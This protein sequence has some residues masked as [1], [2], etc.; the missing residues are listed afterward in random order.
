MRWDTKEVGSQLPQLTAFTI[1]SLDVFDQDSLEE[2]KLR[3]VKGLGKPRFP[4]VCKTEYGKQETPEICRRDSSNI[5]LSI[6]QCKHV[7]KQAKVRKG[8]TSKE[9]R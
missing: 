2:S 9:W 1:S 7:R 5:Q 3:S 4:T 8:M 6:N